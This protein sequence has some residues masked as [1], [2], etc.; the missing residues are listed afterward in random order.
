MEIKV[1]TVESTYLSTGAQ[2]LVYFWVLENNGTY[3]YEYG[4]DYQLNDLDRLWELAF[5]SASKSVS[6]WNEFISKHNNTNVIDAHLDLS[7]VIGFVRGTQAT[8]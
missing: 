4:E 1:Y 3:R 5:D 7:Y 8:K 2:N 6:A